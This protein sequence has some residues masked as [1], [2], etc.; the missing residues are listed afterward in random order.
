MDHLTR[1][2]RALLEKHAVVS[3]FVKQYRR[4]LQQIAGT[5]TP[6]A[7]PTHNFHGTSHLPEVVSSGALLPGTRDVH[8]TN[9]VYLSQRG[10]EHGYFKNGVGGFSFPAE[11]VQAHGGQVIPGHE[12]GRNP[13]M[14]APSVPLAGSGATVI[15]TRPH[16]TVLDAAR[17]A[18]QQYGMRRADKPGYE[19]AYDVARG[20]LPPSQADDRIRE[21]ASAYRKLREAYKTS[22]NVPEHALNL[23]KRA[24]L[25]TAIGLPTGA[26][27]G[28]GIGYLTYRDADAD[29][30]DRRRAMLMG[31]IYGG[32][33]GAG[34]GSVV[35]S[36][37]ESQAEVA[38]I[39]AG[40]E[41]QLQKTRAESEALRARMETEV[42]RLRA[43]RAGIKERGEKVLRALQA[44]S[45]EEFHA[46][47]LD[48]NH[49][50]EF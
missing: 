23:E 15:V 39:R 31:G 33:V 8:G 1:R 28:A 46:K 18:Q 21:R 20:K 27:L 38:A 14:S 25:G 3:P 30:A 5:H 42:G 6:S 37:R 16:P 22:P 12:R 11:H 48:K 26:A 29:A 13:Y 47:L 35:D 41:A 7:A 17:Q 34:I 9:G 50:W 10:P 49:V 36:V 2:V 43:E 4:L 19:T 45:P 40:A 44:M 32:M 24:L